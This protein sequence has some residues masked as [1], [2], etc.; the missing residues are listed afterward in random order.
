MLHHESIGTNKVYMKRRS[1]Q[2]LEGGMK[3]MLNR[4]ILNFFRD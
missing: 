1:T 2:R 4:Y 3:N